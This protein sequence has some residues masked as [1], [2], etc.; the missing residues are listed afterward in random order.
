MQNIVMQSIIHTFLYIHTKKVHFF[1]H[2]RI[3]S[4]NTALGPLGMVHPHFCYN[5]Y[6]F[7]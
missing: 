2:L 6:V 1:S 7:Q 5:L 4:V 3:D